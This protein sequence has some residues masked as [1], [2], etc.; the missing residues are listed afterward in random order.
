M[1]PEPPENGWDLTRDSARGW[2]APAAVAGGGWPLPQDLDHRGNGSYADM[3]TDH[4]DHG[5]V[6]WWTR[7]G[8]SCEVKQTCHFGN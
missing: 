3:D 6:D 4:V 5:I 7:E 1:T 8:W 2:G